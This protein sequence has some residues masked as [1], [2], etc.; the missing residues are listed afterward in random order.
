M[1]IIG[2]IITYAN[3]ESQ[4]KHILIIETLIILLLVLCNLFTT[5][6]E[7]IKSP[8]RFQY[9]QE[10]KKIGLNYKKETDQNLNIFQSDPYSVRKALEI[11]QKNKWNIFKNN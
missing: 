1:G 11:C 2:I 10:M 5:I 3:I 7:I 6:D 9:F 8:Y 4:K